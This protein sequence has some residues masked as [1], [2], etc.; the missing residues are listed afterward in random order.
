VASVKTIVP[1]VPIAHVALET[2]TILRSFKEDVE[3]LLS[4]SSNRKAIASKL[5][6][7]AKP[8]IM[9]KYLKIVFNAIIGP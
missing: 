9:D 7:T 5:P 1:K 2:H 3:S 6:I 8:P 4:V